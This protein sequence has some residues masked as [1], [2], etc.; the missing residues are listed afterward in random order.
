MATTSSYGALDTKA[1]IRGLIAATDLNINRL[2]A[3]CSL[4]G[5]EGASEASLQRAI[6]G[7]NLSPNA[8]NAVRELV[9]KI[10]TLIAKL[11]PLTI[12]FADPTKV[13]RWLDEIDAG[14][15]IV[16]IVSGDNGG[17]ERQ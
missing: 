17:E 7:K 1:L 6:G 2:S 16:I 13:K 10:K 14:K 15:L 5:I 3:L 9:V 4:Y 12:S 11:S 8:D